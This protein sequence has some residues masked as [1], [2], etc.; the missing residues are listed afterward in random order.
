MCLIM[1]N[2]MVNISTSFKTLQEVK[3]YPYMVLIKGT[4]K[5]AQSYARLN[6]TNCF[7]LWVEG[8]GACISDTIFRSSSG[9]G[10]KAGSSH[11]DLD[12]DLADIRN[13]SIHAEVRSAEKCGATEKAGEMA[14]PSVTE[15]PVI[16]ERPGEEKVYAAEESDAVPEKSDVAEKSDVPEKSDAVPAKTDVPEMSDAVPEKTDVAEKS[17][18]VPEKTDVPE[19]SACVDAMMVVVVEEEDKGHTTRLSDDHNAVYVCVCAC[20][21]VCVHVS[22]CVLWISLLVVSM[23]TCVC[24]CAQ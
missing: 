9:D 13:G 5:C 19:K 4:P 1:L 6:M 11:A 16:A 23:H 10:Q 3:Y 17:D 2:L 14:K 8:G 15:K 20:E 22:M 18:A 12:Q 24:V 7:S 21:H